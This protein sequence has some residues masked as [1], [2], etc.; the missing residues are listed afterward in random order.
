VAVNRLVFW[1]NDP[2]HN[3]EHFHT[4]ARAEA[5]RIRALAQPSTNRDRHVGSTPFTSGQEILDEI[6]AAVPL[7]GRITRI[8]IF[9]HA[10]P[11]G[12]GGVGV[13]TDHCGMYMP[14]TPVT[15]TAGC[16]GVLLTAL[17]AAGLTND[18]TFILHGCR[19]AGNKDH[20]RPDDFECTDTADSDEN[21]ARSL[22]EHLHNTLG[23]TSPTVFGHCSSG[24]SG[25][26]TNWRK[27]SNA[28]PH[29]QRAS[30]L[31]AFYERCS[32]CSAHSPRED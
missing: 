23:L 32:G 11:R 18:V 2:H 29:G 31:G 14:G 4:C 16:G 7:V 10:G 17:T 22:Y 19:L 15:P 13:D 1:Q 28:T 6:A 5:R 26:D 27:Y 12:F 24:C 8:H 25:R 3:G 9:G 30:T 20:P 21:F